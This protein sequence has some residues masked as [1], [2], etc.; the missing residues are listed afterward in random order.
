MENTIVKVELDSFQKW[1]LNL[2]ILI[3]IVSIISLLTTLKYTIY[4]DNKQYVEFFISV[5]HDF[6]KYLLIESFIIFN[7]VVNSG[8]FNLQASLGR[9]ALIQLS[10]LIFHSIKRKIG[11]YEHIYDEEEI[12]EIIKKNK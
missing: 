7:E 4:K 2:G 6:I 8:K 12:I 9:I 10:L 11:L 5:Y 3:F 1:L